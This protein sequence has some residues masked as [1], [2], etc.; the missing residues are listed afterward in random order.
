M[1]SGR[2]GGRE[3]VHQNRDTVGSS[4]R[5]VD[6]RVRVRKKKR[7]QKDEREKRGGLDHSPFSSLTAEH[8]MCSTCDLHSRVPH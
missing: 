3:V 8:A 6:W 1:R 4:G 5:H 7:E 2:G